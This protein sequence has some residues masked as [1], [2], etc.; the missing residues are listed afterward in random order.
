MTGAKVIV[1]GEISS[2]KSTVICAAMARLGWQ[3]PGGFFTH[4]GRAGRGGPVLFLETWSGAVHPI[5]RRVAAPAEPGG[6][7]YEFDA[8]VFNRAA[9]TSLRPATAGY[10]VVIDELGLIELGAGPFAQAL[11]NL[12]QG[13][14]PILAVI[15]RR[16]LD[17]WL[18]QFGAVGRAARRF[19]VEAATRD[20]LPLQLAAAFG[21]P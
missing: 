10:P 6:L 11:A 20:A 19:D 14:A 5:A 1:S 3:Q 13:P 8:P 4:W 15:Q 16:A 2:G 21:I 7:P 12:F 9:M 18:V 17:A